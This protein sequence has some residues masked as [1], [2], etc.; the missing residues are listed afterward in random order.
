MLGAGDT[1][2]AAAVAQ[3][4]I[5]AER[6]GAEIVTG[7]QGSDPA[8]VCIAR[9]ILHAMGTSM[10]ASLTR[11]G[12]LQTQQNLMSELT[13]IH[14][15]IGK[16]LEGAPHEVILVL[17]GTS[18]QNAISQARGST[19]SVKCTGIILSKIDGTAKGGVVIPIRQQFGLPVKY[20]GVGEQ[21]D[22][23]IPSRQ[24][25]LWTRSSP[26]WSA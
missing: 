5:W 2:R 1:F 10:F 23:L 18:G 25:R 12:R 9:S 11:T 14:R 6:T 17:D 21:A 22:D 19:E 4:Q 20:V 7:A 8:S 16:R 13:K 15:V 3:L 24:P 26:D